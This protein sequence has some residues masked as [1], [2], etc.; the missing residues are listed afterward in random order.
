VPCICT[1][2][3][4]RPTLEVPTPLKVEE[5]ERHCDAIPVCVHSIIYNTRNH[6]RSQ[7]SIA[8]PAII[9]TQPDC[10]GVDNTR[11]M[12]SG[13]THDQETRPDSATLHGLD[14]NHSLQYATFA[15]PAPHGTFRRASHTLAI[16][17]I[18]VDEKVG[19]QLSP[20]L[21]PTLSASLAPHVR[22][23]IASPAPPISHHDQPRKEG[24][25]PR[26]R[27]SCWSALFVHILLYSRGCYIAALSAN[28]HGQQSGVSRSSLKHSIYPS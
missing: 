2:F 5:K 12:L 26:A 1:A 23:S 24:P 10:I 6:I 21:S 19:E 18:R 4:V 20:P 17:S 28:A 13:L 11:V 15:L 7:T 9:L 22:A 27:L 25:C 14:I 3:K 8:N 16:I